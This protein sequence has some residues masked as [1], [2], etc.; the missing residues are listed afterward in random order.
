MI[1][2]THY[3]L[4]LCEISVFGLLLI[5]GKSE[6]LWNNLR[7]AALWLLEVFFAIFI[8]QTF[9]KDS[10]QEA[11]ASLIFQTIVGFC[12]SEHETHGK[13]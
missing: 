1:Y 6:R 8:V 12:D 5:N 13:L 11:L 9:K 4:A 7:Y 10:N 3:K 2:H